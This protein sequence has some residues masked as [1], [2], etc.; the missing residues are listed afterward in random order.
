MTVIL[1]VDHPLFFYVLYSIQ[2][3]SMPKSIFILVF[4]SFFLLISC[5]NLKSNDQ[6]SKPVSLEAIPQLFEIKN[7]KNDQTLFLNKSHFIQINSKDS[8]QFDSVR[9]SIKQTANSFLAKSDSINLSPLLN[10]CGNQKIAIKIY[11]HD[12][13]EEKQF[14]VSVIPDSDPLRT[15]YHVK[16]RFSH[17]ATSYTQGLEFVGDRLYESSGLYRESTIKEID[18]QGKTIKE[19]NLPENYFGEGITFLNDQFYQLTW[20]ENTWF[21]FDENLNLK[22]TIPYSFE[23]Q[24][25]GLCNDDKQ[26][27]MSN[28]SEEI[29]FLDPHS[30]NIKKKI[31]VYA[32]NTPLYNLNELELV[33]GQLLANIYQ[34]DLLAVIDTSS[35]KV[36]TLLDLSGI[37]PENEMTED[38]DVLNGIAYNK[39]KDMLLVTGKKWPYIFQI[40]TPTTLHNESAINP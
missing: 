12:S 34:Q 23:T 8:I 4:F 1:V 38:T 31:Q 16:N 14:S 6:V 20:K 21:I 13:I 33:N 27:I 22:Q 30:L 9:I 26:L 11:Y 5:D 36:T 25:W 15:T 39:N 17:D 18:L 29:L 7:L 10:H 28:G 2:I 37:L 3:R 32:G 24:G 19:H 35:G 40:A